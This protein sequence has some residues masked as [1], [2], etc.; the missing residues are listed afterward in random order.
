MPIKRA[1][2]LINWFPQ[3][4]WVELRKGFVTHADTGTGEPVESLMAYQGL[5][6]RALFA[7]SD[8]SV[9]DVT[10]SSVT[11]GVTG[12]S[13][14]RIQHINFANTAGNFL[15]CVNGAD[16]PFY[17]SGT[18]WATATITG[19]DASE[20]V[21]VNAFK[22]RLFFISNNST[23]FHYLAVDS[24]QGA[25]T[26]FELGGLMT[27]GGYLVAMGTWSI[28][29]GD[30]PDDYAVFIT[31]RG[32]AIIY[33]GTDP[34]TAATWQLVG[35]F[36]MGAPIGR[37]CLT[38]VGADIAIICIDGVL[39]LSK[40]MIFERSAVVKVS[41]TERIQR[42][43]NESARAYGDN[44]GWQLISYPRGT[45]AILNVPV[46]ENEEQQ[47]YV[48]N[49]NNG[50]W[51][52][53]TGH[54]GSCWELL[55]DTPYFG[56]NEGVVFEADTSGSDDGEAI[57]AVMMTAFSYY[58]SPGLNKRWVECQPLITTDG[59]VSPG[60]TFNVDFKEDAPLSVPDSTLSAS[61][62]WDNAVWDQAIWPIESSVQTDWLA[63]TGVGHCASIR[64]AV[65]VRQPV[66]EGDNW[67]SALWGTAAWYGTNAAPDVTLQ[68]NGFNVA[69]EKGQAYV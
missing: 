69:Y 15:Y 22:S 34:D 47:Q 58:G 45:R 1:V 41:L 26:S 13:N 39:P 23:A 36:N 16:I 42:V 63:V 43:M 4:S 55:D 52:L 19:A 65:D 46:S 2:R 61:A 14:V 12:L 20:F 53:Y 66:I 18:V 3:T 32:Q 60:I 35:V 8:D 28:D 50:A 56:G 59:S 44:F 5:T 38:R 30:G 40:A 57:F 11:T 6:S 9:F 49:T 21:Y 67:S 64:L 62:R 25:A 37:R 29:A 17:Y 24:I 7:G 54:N 27:Q 10:T 68:V 31:S 48:M 51:C 33:A